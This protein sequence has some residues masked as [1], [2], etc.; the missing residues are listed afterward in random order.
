MHG[1][2]SFAFDGKSRQT[3]RSAEIPEPFGW[4]KP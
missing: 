1:H 3:A 2:A 4:R